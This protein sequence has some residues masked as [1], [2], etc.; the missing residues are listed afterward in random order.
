MRPSSPLDDSTT[1]VPYLDKS[2]S[3][4]LGVELGEFLGPATH[5]IE[6]IEGEF[7]ARL[8]AQLLVAAARTHP[9]C[10]PGSSRSAAAPRG[11]RGPAFR[12]GC[13]RTTAPPAWHSPPRATRRSGRKARTLRPCQ[14]HPARRGRSTRRRSPTAAAGWR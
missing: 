2:D 12:P 1:F 13:R 7:S 3:F 5:G 10:G 4:A 9:R 6:V 14:G 11:A 8:E